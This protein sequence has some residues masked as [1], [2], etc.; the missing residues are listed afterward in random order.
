MSEC[1]ADSDKTAVVLKEGAQWC[2]KCAEIS[3]DYPL[4]APE[5]GCVRTCPD[6]APIPDGE[7]NCITCAQLD[8][9]TPFWANGKC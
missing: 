5:E 4:W 1:S 3:D 6:T 7:G 2:R 9:R 8:K